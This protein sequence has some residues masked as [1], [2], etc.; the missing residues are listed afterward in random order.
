[1]TLWLFLATDAG[2]QPFPKPD[3][4]HAWIL[5]VITPQMEKAPAP[6]FPQAVT[7]KLYVGYCLKISESGDATVS[8]MH[9]GDCEAS[10][11]QRH[12]IP[13]YDVAVLTKADLESLRRSTYFTNYPISWSSVYFRTNVICKNPGIQ[14]YDDFVFFDR[15]GHYLGKL[16]LCPGSNDIELAPAPHNASGLPAFNVDLETVWKIADE[17][18]LSQP[19][20]LNGYI[21]PGTQ[22]IVADVFPTATKVEAYVGDYLAVS[23]TGLVTSGHFPQ[24]STQD[25]RHV[26]FV[27]VARNHMAVL[28]RSEVDRLRASI[29]FTQL[30]GIA[31]LCMCDFGHLLTFYD[32][33]GRYLGDFAVCFH[34]GCTQISPEP[35]NTTDLPVLNWD[36]AVV[37]SI[38]DAHHLT[39]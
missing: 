27:P 21:S 16:S 14:A 11:V 5:G 4:Q 30:P 1:M 29:Y 32:A 28:T 22:K 33:A 24:P 7:A 6:L 17:H 39:Q 35:K 26:P 18:Q 25:Q 20:G 23:K 31:S 9:I 38:Y 15:S 37:K 3:S 12:A 36:E 10:S 19:Q 13:A 8:T 2:A 34:C